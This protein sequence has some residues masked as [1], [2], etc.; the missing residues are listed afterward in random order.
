[1]TDWGPGGGLAALGSLTELKWAFMSAPE[2]GLYFW[3]QWG[4][5]EGNGGL[6][7]IQSL[8]GKKR[9]RPERQQRVW[10]QGG[11]RARDG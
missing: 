8:R 11:P 5:G 6:G 1:M 10:V 9:V 7:R 2:F 4:A 3:S